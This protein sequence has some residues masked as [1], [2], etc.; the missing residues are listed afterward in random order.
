MSNFVHCLFS[1]F[2]YQR[3]KKNIIFV[4]YII[5]IFKQQYPIEIK[6]KV[7]QICSV[8][9]P[10]FPQCR[11]QLRYIMQKFQ[12]QGICLQTLLKI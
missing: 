10:G 2:L 5:K 6:T 8:F 11:K 9:K 3:G 4:L 12:S 1:C 7:L